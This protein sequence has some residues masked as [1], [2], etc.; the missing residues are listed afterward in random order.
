MRVGVIGV[1]SIGR[2][3]VGSI[4]AGQAGA[5]HVV[6]LAARPGSEARLAEVAASAG[7]PWTT[8]AL[9][10]VAE[11]PDIVV[12]AASQAAVRQYAVPLLEAGANIVGACCGSTPNHI[13]A[14]RT[15]IDE[16]LSVQA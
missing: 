15:A 12:E 6:G 2:Y 14:F 4:R 1:G 8:D 7:C 9:A 5:A 3:L 13:R 11:K 16:Y 10:L